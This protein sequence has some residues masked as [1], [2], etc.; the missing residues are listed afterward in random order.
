MSIQYINN[1][2]N[3]KL[4]EKKWEALDLANYTGIAPSDISKY[5]KGTVKK[6][7]ADVFYK[8]YKAFGDPCYEAS[9]IVYPEL[10]LK[11]NKFIRQQRTPFGEFMYQFEESK[12]SIEH[13][14]LKTGIDENRLKD[15]YFRKASI[16]AYELILIE[17]AIGKNQGELFEMLYGTN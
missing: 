2:I 6:L 8:L 10:T 7:K 15:L 12:N 5:R 16:E 11:P 14:S 9:K 3:E 17:K 1:Y 13:I 4:Q